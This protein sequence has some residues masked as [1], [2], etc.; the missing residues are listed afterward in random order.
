MR[1]LDVPLSGAAIL[2]PRVFGDERG[3]FYESWNEQT[4][5]GLGLQARF[6]QDNHSS[7][8]RGILRGLHW[9]V[10]TSAQDKL[11]RCVRGAVYDV[12]VD[13]RRSSPTF[14]KSVGVELSEANRRM[15]WVPRGFAHGFLTLSDI[16]EVCYKV[17]AYWSRADERGL[18][19]ND[20]AGGIAW[21][22][23]GVAPQL[24][25]RDAA[26]PL[27]SQLAPSDLP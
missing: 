8:Q 7:S 4:L 6:V 21:P 3:W 14:G 16:A 25:P 2:E 24:N 17:T 11:V 19:W 27:L 9:Q 5:A 20:P 10:G 26:F 1:R 12:I 15:L 22:D 18:R 13:L 23:V